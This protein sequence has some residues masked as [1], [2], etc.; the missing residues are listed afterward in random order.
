MLLNEA[1]GLPIRQSDVDFL[2]PNLNEDLQLYV[3]PFLFYKSRN[4][5]YQA[6]HSTIRK[7]FDIAV[8]KVNE[9]DT[10]TAKRMLSFPEV[11]ETM[12]G[13]S[14]GSHRG[15]GLG[16]HRGEVIYREIVSNPIF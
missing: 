10:E 7:F 5:E 9:G 6:V 2:I 15:R 12:I 8:E 13:L 16:E 1:L 11:N 4:P 14:T 3:D